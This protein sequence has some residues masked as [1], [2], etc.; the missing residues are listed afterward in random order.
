MAYYSI[1]LKNWKRKKNDKKST[2]KVTTTKT[3]KFQ[4]TSKIPSNEKNR[5]ARIGGGGAYN[6]WNRF[7]I[8]IQVY[9]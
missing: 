4:A 8:Y 9:I 6:W 7:N 5:Q 1:I 3:D 2:T